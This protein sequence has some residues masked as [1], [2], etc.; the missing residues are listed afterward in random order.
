MP[1]VLNDLSYLKDLYIF[2]ILSINN[3]YS[4]KLSAISADGQEG[5]FSAISTVKQKGAYHRKSL[6][7]L[8]IEDIEVRRGFRGFEF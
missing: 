8:G 2:Y 7:C 1:S 3:D 6:D 5:L 4:G